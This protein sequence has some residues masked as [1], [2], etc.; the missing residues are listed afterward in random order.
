MSGWCSEQRECKIRSSQEFGTLG[1]TNV[2]VQLLTEQEERN[3]HVV[4]NLLEA[5]GCQKL[6]NVMM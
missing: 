5:S 6:C 2:D 1:V 4:E 3:D